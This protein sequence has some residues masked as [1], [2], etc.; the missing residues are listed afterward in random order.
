M[1]EPT[2]TS[3]FP[4]DDLPPSFHRADATATSAQ[5]L[6]RF[7][8][9]AQ[10][11]MY[12]LAAVAGAV[13]NRWGA[14]LAVVF[15]LAALG[16]S[17]FLAS[18]DSDRTWYLARGG[19][20]SVKSL[21]WLYACGGDPFP[22]SA[23]PRENDQRYQEQLHAIFEHLSELDWRLDQDEAPEAITETMRSL[24]ASDL[25]RRKSAYQTW[26]IDD[27]HRYY[28]QKSGANHKLNAKWTMLAL[29][30]TF[31][32]LVFGVVRIVGDYETDLLGLA[33]VGAASVTAWVETRQFRSLA[34]SYAATANDLE[35]ISINVP[36]IDTEQE[37]STF[38]RD[39]ERAV[40]REHSIW[41]TRHGIRPA[42]E[43]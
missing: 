12:V 28:M 1:A 24:R 42:P 37:W 18:V 25:A 6:A 19:A 35:A 36:Y 43:S 10:L 7:A 5:K 39:A 38:V 14:V 40:G 29:V 26:R 32:G 23:S 27:Q 9:A 2:T 41:L 17:L 4:D 8:T 16:L 33:A 21:A 34:T 11:W 22:I 30:V 3:P 13:P 15:F 20:E 31:V